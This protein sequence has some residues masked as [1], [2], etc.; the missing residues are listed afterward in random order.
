MAHAFFPSKPELP[1]PPYTGLDIDNSCSERTQINRVKITDKCTT[2]NNN[3]NNN[4]RQLIQ[5]LEL[6]DAFQ[7]K[8]EFEFPFTSSI[9]IDF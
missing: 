4:T 6:E 7:A 8:N 1:S 9:L 2:N 3:T 5:L